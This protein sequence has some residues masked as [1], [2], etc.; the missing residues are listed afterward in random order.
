MIKILYLCDRQNH[1]KCPC[2]DECRHTTVEKYALNEPS[3]RRFIPLENGDLWED[4]CGDY[5][6]AEAKEMQFLD[7]LWKG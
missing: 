6:D 4:A 7:E 1:C 2:F 3:E 5:T